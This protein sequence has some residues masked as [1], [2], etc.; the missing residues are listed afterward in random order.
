MQN[1]AEIVCIVGYNMV[2]INRPARK[3]RQL[4]L[5]LILLPL[6]CHLDNNSILTVQELKNLHSNTIN[7]IGS[8]HRIQNCFHCLG[9]KYSVSEE[10]LETFKYLV[11]IKMCQ[12]KIMLWTKRIF[13]HLHTTSPLAQTSYTQ[14][15][16]IE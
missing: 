6:F 4:S 5:Q 15:I 14:R 7:W 11:I 9:A 1:A 3:I 16:H 10:V 13:I 12:S 2:I 8:Q